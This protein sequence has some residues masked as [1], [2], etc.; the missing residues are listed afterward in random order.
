MKIRIATIP[1]AG[2]EIKEPLSS[3]SINKRLNE[4]KD[5]GINILADP[6]VYLK[7]NKNIEGAEA[8]GKIHVTYSQCC[9]RCLDPLPQNSELPFHL[10]IKHREEGDDQFDDIGIM[11]YEGEYA[12]LQETLEEVIILSIDIFWAP[13]LDQKGNCSLCQ[14]NCAEK[15]EETDVKVNKFGELLKKAGVQ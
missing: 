15:I 5:S 14:K 2:F 3:I 6:L 13:S 12:D 9:S 7:V 4:V 1:P 8:V 11:Y 10:I